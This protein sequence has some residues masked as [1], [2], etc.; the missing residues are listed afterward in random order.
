[1][2]LSVTASRAL[3]LSRATLSLGLFILPFWGARTQGPVLFETL[4]AFAPQDVA[5]SGARS[6]R[7]DAPGSPFR[8]ALE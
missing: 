3:T 7:L 8:G 5:P 4:V 2:T 1:M 6:A